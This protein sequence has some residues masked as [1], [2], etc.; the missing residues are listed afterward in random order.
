MESEYQCISPKNAISGRGGSGG[1]IG[2]IAPPLKPRK[3]TFFAMILY[4]SEN[5]N[6][7]IRPFCR[8]LFCHSSVVKSTS[9]LLLYSSERIMSLDCQ[10]LLQSPPLKLLAGSAPD[11]RI[12][13]GKTFRI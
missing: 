2:A 8:P 12:L 10:I 3:A 5:S 11:F 13:T 9:S 1:A 6:R 4:N 7:D